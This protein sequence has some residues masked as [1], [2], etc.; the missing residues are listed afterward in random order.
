MKPDDALHIRELSSL[1]TSYWSV[2]TILA[3][4][5]IG[6]FDLF[7]GNQ[8]LSPHV[9]ATRLGVTE[10]IARMLLRALLFLKLIEIHTDN[11]VSLTK[12]GSYFKTSHV[13]SLANVAKIWGEEHYLAWRF[14]DRALLSGEEQFSTMT[15]KP[16]FYWLIQDSKKAKEYYDAMHIYALIDYRNVHEK[17]KPRPHEMVLDLGAGAGTLSELLARHYPQTTFVLFDL[18]MA[19]RL[20]QKRLKS[21]PFRNIQFNPGDFF[22]D[23]LPSPVDHILLSRVIHDW[24]DT[25]ALKILDRCF[26]ALN[27]NGRIHLLEHLLPIEINDSWGALLNLN[28]LVITGSYERT[29]TEYLELLTAAG[30]CNPSISFLP[31]GISVITAKKHEEKK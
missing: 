14:L 17:I 21:L 20:A 3:S 18:P 13:F 2:Q 5:N 27:N 28:M 30:F 23:P 19:I 25:K 31:S 24:E 22:S 6:F 4:I 8:S 29:K 10:K 11:T 1:L 16:F 15:G 26:E 9:I 7:D 12:K